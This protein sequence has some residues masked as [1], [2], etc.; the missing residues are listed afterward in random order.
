MTTCVPSA[1]KIESA[2]KLL[3]LFVLGVLAS[4]ALAE[5]HRNPG[6]TDPL[7]VD[8]YIHAVPESVSPV[9]QT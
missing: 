9:Q 3:M 5:I 6:H 8:K 4:P 7:P 2:M 1:Y